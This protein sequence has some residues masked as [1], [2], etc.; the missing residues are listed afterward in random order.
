MH[1][2]ALSVSLGLLAM[3]SMVNGNACNPDNCANAVTG[4][5]RGP[6]FSTTA[7]SDCSSFM[8]TTSTLAPV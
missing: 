8:T 5:R 1:H 3:V 6:A 2:H 7:K 4:T